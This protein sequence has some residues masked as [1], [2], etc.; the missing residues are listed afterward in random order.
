MGH[1]GGGHR[2]V[3]PPLGLLSRA[4][5]GGVLPPPSG[6]P[7]AGMLCDDRV[8]VDCRLNSANRVLVPLGF[9]ATFSSS[10]N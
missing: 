6:S 1:R 3:L 9:S 5:F 2:A 10:D 8:V 7:L 4:A